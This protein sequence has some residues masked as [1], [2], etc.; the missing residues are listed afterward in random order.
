MGSDFSSCVWHWLVAC[1]VSALREH[2]WNSWTWLKNVRGEQDQQHHHRETT[3]PE[4]VPN[5]TSLDSFS[6]MART[7]TTMPSTML[8]AVRMAVSHR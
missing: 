8:A 1:W 3:S 4:M 6:L 2:C 5:S 7:S